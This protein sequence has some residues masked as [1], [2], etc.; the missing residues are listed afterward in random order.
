MILFAS[1]IFLKIN[2]LG[3]VWLKELVEIEDPLDK[4]L[5]DKDM[6]N[7]INIMWIL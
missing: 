1:N 4:L 3:K 2:Y 7:Y 6:E 5:H